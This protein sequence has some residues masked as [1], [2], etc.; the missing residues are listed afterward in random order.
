MLKFSKQANRAAVVGFFGGL[1]CFGVGLLVGLLGSPISSA[2]AASPAAEKR[3]APTWPYPDSLDALVAAPKFHWV[4]FE[5][6]R[7]RVLEVTVPPHVRK[8]L[9]TH[10]WPSVLYRELSCPLRYFD[11]S[12]QV[13]A[14]RVAQTVPTRPYQSPR[15]LAGAR[16]SA[17]R[18]KYGRGSRPVHSGRIQ[19]VTRSE[20]KSKSASC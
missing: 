19:A 8:P 7:V 17:C 3:T 15:P 5:N 13:L 1:A 20:M 11:A 2:Q 9:H 6:D 14:A 10:R 4:L 16:S 18:G 12:G